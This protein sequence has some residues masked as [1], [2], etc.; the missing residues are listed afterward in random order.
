MKVKSILK[1]ETLLAFPDFTEPSH[2]IANSLIS[3]QGK[4]NPVLKH[5]TVEA[6]DNPYDALEWETLP[7]LTYQQEE[8]REI[9]QLLFHL[10]AA[11]RD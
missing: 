2:R 1:T 3:T 4:L 6:G 7:P 8:V 10:T 5:Y 11:E 9:P